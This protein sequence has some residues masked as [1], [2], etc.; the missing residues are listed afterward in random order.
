[1]GDWTKRFCGARSLP[2]AS[3][4]FALF[5]FAST[6]GSQTASG[7]LPP[8][9]PAYAPL[10]LYDGSWDSVG[11]GADAKT[12][13]L[14]NHCARTFKFFVCEQVVD[15]NSQA[16]IIF[17]PQGA[18]GQTQTYF[19]QV[20][21]TNASRPGPWNKL[22][23]TGDNWLYTS[24]SEE[25]NTTVHWRTVNVFTGKNKIHYE[26]GRSADGKTW[27]TTMSGDERRADQ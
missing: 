2:A 6:A 10:R 16:L 11:A 27:Q 22:E 18:R 5:V 20:L 8:E 14:T 4:A 3:M 9:D 23:I 17:L 12:V 24:D 25:N 13:H 21:A 26:I 19:T 1:M 15:G 7:A